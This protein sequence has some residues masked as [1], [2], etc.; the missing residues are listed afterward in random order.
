MEKCFR[1]QIGHHYDATGEEPAFS[2]REPGEECVDGLVLCKGHALEAKL[3]GQIVC[4]D[5][6]LFHV[7]DL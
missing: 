1:W 3:E 6:M 2:C 4:W 7:E 5:E